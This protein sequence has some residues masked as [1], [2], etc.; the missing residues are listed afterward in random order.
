MP[1]VDLDINFKNIILKNNISPEIESR[2]ITCDSFRES[3]FYVEK[4]FRL[5]DDNIIS[6]ILLRNI[7]KGIS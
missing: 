2:K 6:K 1:T 5:F 7:F 4:I 3:I